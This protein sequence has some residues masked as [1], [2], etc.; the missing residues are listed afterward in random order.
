LD[1]TNALT[2]IRLTHVCEV[3]TGWRMA[4]QLWVMTASLMN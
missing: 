4:I 3:V 1:V 2:V